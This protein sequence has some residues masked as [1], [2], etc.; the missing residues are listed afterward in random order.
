MPEDS[1]DDSEEV[2]ETEEDENVRFEELKQGIS[3]IKCAENGFWKHDKILFISENEKELCSRDVEDRKVKKI[4]IK[5]I[6]SVEYKKFDKGILKHMK[7][8]EEEKCLVI[9]ALAEDNKI[10]NFEFVGHEI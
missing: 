2:D 9:R 5:N 8:T 3:V 7:G 4:P 1:S 6:Q 10:K